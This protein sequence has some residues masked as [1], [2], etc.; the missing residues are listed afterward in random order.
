MTNAPNDGAGVGADD[1]GDIPPGLDRRA[2]SKRIPQPE[3]AS[4]T[5]PVSGSRTRAQWSELIKASWRNCVEAIICTGQLLNEAKAELG[6]GHWQEMARHDLPFSLRQAEMLM[7]IANDA[8]IAKNEN[9]AFLPPS[10]PVLYEL[11]KLDDKTFNAMKAEGSINPSMT[12]L[13]AENAV[14]LGKHRRGVRVKKHRQARAGIK[15]PKL[16]RRSLYQTPGPAETGRELCDIAASLSANLKLSP[17]I[18]DA[19]VRALTPKQRQIVGDYSREI[20]A[21]FSH[22]IE[23]CRNPRGEGERHA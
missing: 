10:V 16:P 22:V 5:L 6:H 8:R 19:V 21:W 1:L 14:W 17:P 18:D 13:V 20:V 3:A 2:P 12:K 9:F 23:L 7:R 15:T 11:T 4:P